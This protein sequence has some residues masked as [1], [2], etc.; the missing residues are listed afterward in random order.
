MKTI[1]TKAIC[2]AFFCFAVSFALLGQQTAATGALEDRSLS[3]GE[4]NQVTVSDDFE[5]TL[6]KGSYGV[7][8]TTDVALTPYIQVYVRAKNLFI[9]FDSKS[10]PKELK[11]SLKGKDGAA[12]VFRATVR[13]PELNGITLSDNVVLSAADPF[14]GNKFTM[15]LANKSQVKALKLVCNSASL[16]LKNNAI[17]D[18]NIEADKEITVAS[19]N[20]SSLTASLRTENLTLQAD[21]SSKLTVNQPSGTESTI[22]AKGSAKIKFSGEGSTLMLKS[23]R[24][25]EIDALNFTAR[26]VE[27]KLDGG[28]AMVNATHHLKLDIAD[29]TTLNFTGE[30]KIE[31]IRVLKSSV[32]PY[33]PSSK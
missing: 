14:N 22:E 13:L 24:N 19:S 25:P 31:I 20:S 15:E 26:A 21:N 32:A 29:G 18:V 27:T 28:T 2:T 9:A 5:V 30:P 12:N 33:S 3:V 17:A 7:T 10:V 8:V 4:F 6:V 1:F 16:N 11:K 23:D